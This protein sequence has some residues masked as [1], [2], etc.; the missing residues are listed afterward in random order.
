MI[1]WLL[2]YFIKLQLICHKSK[3]MDEKDVKEK[4][5][6]IGKKVKGLLT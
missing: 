6:Q 5:I 4:V 1:G 2:A 3:E